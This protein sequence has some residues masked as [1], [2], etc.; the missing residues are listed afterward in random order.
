[1]THGERSVSRAG[2]KTWRDPA[3]AAIVRARGEEW[4]YLRFGKPPL[5][6][7]GEGGQDWL[8]A[9][10]HHRGPGAGGSGGERC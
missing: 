10:G 9:T 4:H 1:M 5:D 8:E 7:R 3:V 6:S 2:E